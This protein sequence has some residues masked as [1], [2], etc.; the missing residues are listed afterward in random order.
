LKSKKIEYLWNGNP[1]YW[2]RH[3]PVL[4]P[5]VGKLI[6]NEYFYNEKTFHLGQHGFARDYEFKV[7]EQSETSIT[8]ELKSNMQTLENY[9]FEFVLH[10]KYTLLENQVKTEYFVLNPSHS[11]DLYFSIGAHPAF[12]CPF[13]ENQQRSEYQ[14]I[15]DNDQTPESLDKDAG[16]ALNKTY[17]IFKEKGFLTVSDDIF[18]KDAL[19]F[20]PN[21]FSE[22]TFMHQ[23]TQKKYLKIKFQN[24]PFLGIWSSKKSSKIS[25][26]V[27][28]EPWHGIADF[29]NHTKEFTQKKGIIK[30]SPSMIFE[31]NFVIEIL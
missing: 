24:F 27:C 12:N 6:D 18:D 14:L 7:I 25:P 9:P 30:L 11:E 8:F 3:A 31:C 28:I 16:I 1:E 15:F 2:N 21:P 13:E 4:F 19:I 23:P 17:P 22:V 20:A 29:S 10:I 26:F 5:I